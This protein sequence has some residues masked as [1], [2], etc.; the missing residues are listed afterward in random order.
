MP[1][2]MVG[3]AKMTSP[4]LW[5]VAFAFWVIAMIAMAVLYAVLT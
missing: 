5:P 3:A 1:V 2:R 4:D